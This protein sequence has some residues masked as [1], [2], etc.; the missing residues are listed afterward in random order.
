MSITSLKARF[1]RIVTE[2]TEQRQ[3]LALTYASDLTALVTDRLLN[4]GESAE[5]KKFPLYSEK[6]LGVKVAEAIVK[7][8]NKPSAKIKAGE[9][10]Y[11]DIR[12]VLGLPTDKRTHSFTNDMIK[13]IRPI[14][15]DNNKYLTIIEI[16]ASDAPNQKKLNENSR[17]MKTNLLRANVKERQLIESLNQKRVQNIINK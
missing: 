8:S 17:R 7:K 9:T 3:D 6:N 11:K 5:G 14:V 2:I 10:S 13:S 16:S 12:R 15:V 4:E 1:A